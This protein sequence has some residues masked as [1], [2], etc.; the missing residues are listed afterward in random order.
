[1]KKKRNSPMPAGKPLSSR[2]VHLPLSLLSTSIIWLVDGDYY[3]ALSPNRSQRNSLLIVFLL[4]C[5]ISKQWT[6][7]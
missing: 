5:E 7:K 3:G 2:A 6:R 4:L 1:M